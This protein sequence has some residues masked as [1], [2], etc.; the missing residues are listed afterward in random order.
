MISTRDGRVVAIFLISY[1]RQNATK[2]RKRH[3]SKLPYFCARCAFLWRFVLKWTYWDLVRSLAVVVSRP[4]LVV[5]LRRSLIFAVICNDFSRFLRGSLV[6]ISALRKGS[7]RYDA[8]HR[9]HQ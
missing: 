7:H 1:S 8:K 3:K 9:N 6:L 5:V 2:K 4:L